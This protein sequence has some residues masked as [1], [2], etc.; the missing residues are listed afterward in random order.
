MPIKPSEISAMGH[1]EEEL[2]YDISKLWY[3][4]QQISI[5]QRATEDDIDG[6]KEEMEAKLDSFTD[7]II[8]NMDVKLVE[9]HIE[10]QQQVL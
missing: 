6:S 4:V 1:V 5:L 7:K 10:R 9:V 2:Q 8:A 3:Q